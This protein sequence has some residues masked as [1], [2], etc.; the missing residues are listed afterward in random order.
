MAFPLRKS[1]ILISLISLVG[2]GLA[3]LE[4]LQSAKTK[5]TLPAVRA[6][7]CT[8]NVVSRNDGEIV[9]E[10]ECPD[11]KIVR[12]EEL[13]RIIALKL[14]G[15]Q[16]D[17]EPGVPQLPAVSQLL[18]CLPGQVSA[19][20]LQSETETRN[21]G[22]MAALP[23]DFPVDSR[24]TYESQDGR[25]ESALDNTEPVLSWRER[26]AHTLLKQ[27][28]WPPQSVEVR[29]GG[30]FRG[31]RLVSVVFHPVQVD[32]QHGIARITKRAR[33]RV[34]VPRAETAATRLPDAPAETALLRTMLGPLAETARTDR[35]PEAFNGA[36]QNSLDDEPVGGRW[37]L[38]VRDEGIIRVRGD[39][40]RLRGV[41][42]DQINPIY[43][44]VKNRGREILCHF[45]GAGD[46]HFDD[47][48]YVEFYATPNVQT[49]Q[50]SSPSYYTDPYSP[51]N[52]YWLSWND[53]HP[54]LRLGEETG[55]HTGPEWGTNRVRSVTN[56]RTTLHFENDLSFDR[57]AKSSL[58]WSSRLQALGPLSIYEDHWFWGDY[59][60][61]FTSRTFQVF[62]PFPDDRSLQPVSIRA[63]LQG[64]S[65]SD[66][67]GTGAGMHR[68]VVYLNGQTSPGWAA[69]RRTI[70][71]TL[72]PDWSGQTA[73]IVQSTSADSL[74][75]TSGDLVSGINTFT[76]SLPGDGPSGFTDKVF[77]NWFDVTYDRQLRAVSNGFVKFRFDTTR[78]DTF[79][80]DLRGFSSRT[81]EVWRLGHSRLTNCDMHVVSRADESPSWAARF[82][83]ISDAPYDIIA[84]NERYVRPPL[85]TQPE[86]SIEDL[87][88]PANGGARYLMIY[89]DSFAGDLS[90]L[91]LD[92]LRRVTFDGSVDTIRLS[93]VY[94]QFN[95]GITNAEAIRNFL[96]YAYE[97]WTI[98]PTHVCLIGDG[99]INNRA[100][101]QSGNLLPS[102]YPTTDEFG[103]AAA[104][105]LFGQIS[106][107]PW[108][109]IPDIAV[110]R[111]SCRSPVELQS[112][113]EKLVNYEDPT[114]SDYN[115]PFH[116]T[117]LFVADGRD[118]QFNFGGDFSEPTVAV[119]NQNCNVARVYLDS[120]GGG[121][122][123]A[124][125]R[126]A[127]NK[128]AVVVNYNGH[129]GGG[130][131]S[132]NNLLDVPGVRLLSNRAQLP[133]ISNFTCY[134]GSFDDRDQSAVLGEALLFSRNVRE[135][136]VGA[137]GVYSSTGVGW[138][139]AGIAM[140]GYLYDFCMEPPG[141]TQGEIV[142]INKARF[143]SNRGSTSIS[144]D[145]WQAMMMM[146]TLLGDP[147]VHLAMP[148]QVL[149]TVSA[150]TSIVSRTD[151]IYFSGTLPWD[152]EARGTSTAIY[153]FPYNGDSYSYTSYTIW[154]PARQETV[155][156][157]FTSFQSTR[158]PLVNTDLFVP[159]FVRTRTL[160]S[161][162]MPVSPRRGGLLATPEGRAVF[163]AADPG[164][165]AQNGLPAVPPRTAVFSLPIYLADSLQD[166]RIN[167]VEVLPAGVL[168]DDSTFQI[169]ARILHRNGIANVR[170]RGF[171][172]PAQGPVVLDTV[173]MMS[174][175][176]LTWQTPW[177]GPH[178]VLGGSYRVEFLVQPNNANAYLSDS[179]TL[180]LE[181][182][183]D[184]SINSYGGIVPH[185]EPGNQPYLVVPIGFNAYSGAR[186]IH[187]VDLLTQA[188]HDTT[189]LVHRPPPLHDTTMVLIVDSFQ[190]RL[191][192]TDPGQESNLFNVKV[193]MSF[194]PMFYR[195]TL[196]LDPENTVRELT[197][198]NNSY[199]MTLNPPNLYP[200][201]NQLGSFIPRIFP[202]NNMT[203]VF[204][205][206]GIQDSLWLNLA[207]GSLLSDSTTLIYG[208][209]VPLSN[210]ELSALKS[211]GALSAPPGQTLVQTYRVLLADSTDGLA[212]GGHVHVTRN[213]RLTFSSRSGAV[214]DTSLMGQLTL[215]YQRMGWDVWRQVANLQLANTRR[216]TVAD[217][218]ITLTG[219]ISGD[220]ASLGRFAVMRLVDSLPPTIDL[221]V[222]GLKFSPSSFVPRHPEIWVALSD[223]SG[224]DHSAGKFFASLDGDTL[225]DADVVWSDTSGSQE[226][227]YAL[228][229]P[230]L[231]PGNHRIRVRATDNTGL[232]DS[233]TVDFAVSGVFGF[234]WV[235]NYPNPFSHVT[236]V[237]YVLTD[238]TSEF[239]VVKIYTVA[240]RYIRSLRESQRIVANYRELVWDGRDYNYNEVANG[241]YFARIKAKQ[242]KQEVEK[243]IK[244]AKIR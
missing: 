165:A 175:D 234:D 5:S 7:R 201:T 217:T 82:H 30:V 112:Y 167:N 184:L 96:K 192:L 70:G 182:A 67:T 219:L 207:P 174:A 159:Q 221:S 203:Q 124:A 145:S 209:P 20:V 172:Q 110:G 223:Y 206:P 136:P 161:L 64:F 48:D 213:I 168:L 40:L 239:V 113:V 199:T 235:I 68:A 29:E 152:P 19:Q 158:V 208:S 154:D 3:G 23:Q 147:G 177:L 125:L 169:Q 242:G 75:I 104:D 1:I 56:V 222:G 36:T 83:L 179:Y 226:R 102:L 214:G 94:E 16:A 131:W 119:M 171:F 220:A 229:R 164:R 224:I 87:R 60:R 185:L 227:A 50:W 133:F 98:R 237:A 135:D 73:V 85:D 90:L 6:T 156:V 100:N 190:V 211:V 17:F 238:E 157:T 195:V 144:F 155:R 45:V 170:V 47:A 24:P 194:K 189:I 57:L 183:V 54:G 148:Q 35:M 122:G 80:L 215:V 163:F 202:Q 231:T 114:V 76:V 166:V 53:G 139:F 128:G 200:A 180:P 109:I 118:P 41:P 134:V 115:S 101:N 78:G 14:D 212:P 37:K 46:G 105:G 103:I 117:A 210:T 127:F 43:L 97:H 162:P 12:D 91:R 92:S 188:I 230:E 106:G 121:Q 197:R 191:T 59:I 95:Y 9:F 173:A 120:L 44:H 51:D 218:L 79:V 42:V 160:N 186:E 225:H 187:S 74:A 204:W 69:G 72:R 111:I 243:T 116:S 205:K 99:I 196:N 27:G 11:L 138:A 15:S 130:L 108:D 13:G 55:W 193:P 244:M 126:R 140:Q 232:T 198:L 34:I 39:S 38:I 84:F 176:G 236:T 93:Q 86:T 240:G 123:P 77:A 8:E 146:M 241:V 65:W 137:I 216:D 66:V 58:Q 153:A 26:S 33:I 228:I 71:D 62:L 49:Y 150:D 52:V 143:W 89:H 4:K 149:T 81:I 107:P 233:V 88:H 129:G 142:Q 2:S 18:D 181:T 21:V 141:L 31:H 22:T 132:Q 25:T 61:G 10:W 63:A 151:T 32:A 28:L 178:P